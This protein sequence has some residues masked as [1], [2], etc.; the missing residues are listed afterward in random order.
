MIFAV[1]KGRAG[2]LMFQLGAI[3]AILRRPTERVYLINFFALE[4]IFPSLKKHVHLISLPRRIDK[5]F[6][7]IDSALRRLAQ[8]RVI[9]SVVQHDS[10]PTAIR[11]IRGL[12]P[13]TWFWGGFCQDEEIV[14][15]RLLT[16]LYRSDIF[17]LTTAA[18]GPTDNLGNL[19]SRR[20]FVHVRRADFSRFPSPEHPA[21][22]P[23]NWLL[24]QMQAV[25]DEL[26][27]VHFVV[28]SDEPDWARKHI[29]GFPNAFVLDLNSRDSFALMSA[30]DA[31]I[32]S[33][34]TFSWWAAHF[35]S[36][37]SD[38]PFIAPYL[39]TGWRLGCWDP[40]EKIAASFLRFV[41]VD[42]P[43]FGGRA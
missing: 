39:W 12:L 18:D 42:T 21:I 2:N 16:S 30:C 36:Q 26:K 25:R 20:C 41:P 14:S 8:S 6:H 13:L 23:Q 5:M 40:H 10:H 7:W 33:P 35:A 22:L 11:R 15:V 38:G 24:G 4:E 31:G 37:R 3:E 1:G 19:S 27:D 32:L 28:L 9:G 29:A 17:P 34:S 43:Q